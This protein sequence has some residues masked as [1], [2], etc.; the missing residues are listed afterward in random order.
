MAKRIL[1]PH[2][3]RRGRVARW[4]DT[5]RQ[6]VAAEARLD[7]PLIEQ[8]RCALRPC[9]GTAAVGIAPFSSTG[10][11]ASLGFGSL[12]VCWLYFAWQ[13]CNSIR[14]RDLRCYERMMTCSYSACCAA[15]R[16]DSGCQSCWLD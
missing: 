16:Y 11:I 2:C 8:D 5:V 13:A 6:A 9:G 12:R 4:L 3:G 15:I 1:L 10:W 14:R 7:T